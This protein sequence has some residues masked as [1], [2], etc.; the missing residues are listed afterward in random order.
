[1]TH[2]TK[3]IAPL[4]VGLRPHFVG[5]R[6]YRPRRAGQRATAPRFT[7][8]APAL[9]GRSGRTLDSPAAASVAYPETTYELGAPRLTAGA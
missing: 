4:W 8:A 6:G 1:M 7:P 5:T 3:Q 9:V 2:R